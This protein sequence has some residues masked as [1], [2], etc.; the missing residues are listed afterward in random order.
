MENN[1]YTSILHEKKL[2]D[3]L[4]EKGLVF[5]TAE[6]CT[7]GLVAKR[8][9]D[10]S[11]SSAVFAGG[12]VTYSNQMK[13]KLLGVKEETLKSCGAVSHETAYEMVKGLAELTGADI[14][15]SLTG[16]AG[17]GG[18][19]EEKPVGLVYVGVI[20][21]GKIRTYKLLLGECGTRAKIRRAAS[22]FALKKAFETIKKDIL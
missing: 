21:R 14:G 13:I 15:V 20:Y 8:V 1:K 5:A 3:A 18:G 12:V 19:S 17:P 4:H 7:G 9:T 11:G 2:V 10:I 16:I 6:S 22:D